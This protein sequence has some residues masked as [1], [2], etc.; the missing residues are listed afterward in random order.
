MKTFN[1]HD[2]HNHTANVLHFHG[3]NITQLSRTFGTIYNEHIVNSEYNKHELAIVSTWTDDNK[4]YLFQQCKRFDIPLINCVPVDYDITQTWYMPNKIKWFIQVLE[5]TKQD[6][7]MFLDGYDV[8]LTHLDDILERF[9]TQPYKILFGPSCNNYPDV[10]IDRIPL[11]TKKGTY[12]YFN[13]GC[14]IG[15]RE[16]LLKFYKEAL[17]FV[18]LPNPWNSE[19][20]ILRHAFAKYSSDEKQNFIGVDFNC[21]IFRSMGVTDS[22]VNI[23]TSEISFNVNRVSNKRIIVTGSDG[24]IGKELV[25]A[26]HLDPTNIVYEIDRKRGIEA[27]TIRIL[28]ELYDIDVV[29]HLAAQTSVFNEDNDQIVKDN[30][31]TFVKIVDLCNKYETKL[32]Y[33]SSSTANNVNTTS[34]YGLSK[35]FNEE[36]AAIYYSHATG[37]RLHN[38]YSE[39]PREGTLMWHILNDDK[40]QL[41]NNGKNKRHFTHV[42]NAVQGLIYASTTDEK[43]LNCYNP[44][45]MTT[46]EF[47]DIICKRFNK[48]YSLIDQVRE[49]DRVCQEIDYS[50]PN[51]KQDYIQVK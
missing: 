20:F 15:Y 17:D 37:V 10:R 1:I 38:V 49:K 21:E 2:E 6:I 42:S 43:L 18:T 41:Y 27:D 48:S 33:A 26:L 39:T 46:A 28:F 32:V 31:A 19:Q 23:Q 7:V 3:Q 44:Q 13:A 8:L 24:F 36:Y 11:R 16:D 14:V 50:I 35:K 25:K 4:C 5:R 51:I 40:I 22:S 30:I 34:L 9:K 12:R 29:Y 45:E 47:T